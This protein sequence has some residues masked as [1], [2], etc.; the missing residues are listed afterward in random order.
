MHAP[1]PSVAIF[2]PLRVDLHFALDDHEALTTGVALVRQHAARG[3][4]VSSDARAI[5][6]NSLREQAA[7]SGTALK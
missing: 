2:L 6:C 3:H 1:G 5:R 7:N 4:L